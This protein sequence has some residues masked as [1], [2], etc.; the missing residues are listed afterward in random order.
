LPAAD[1]FREGRHPHVRHHAAVTVRALLREN[2]IYRN[3]V[4]GNITLTVKRSTGAVTL[5]RHCEHRSA[6]CPTSFIA[7]TTRVDVAGTRDCPP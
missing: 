5:D 1:L 3:G 6:F 4:S 7:F 2:A